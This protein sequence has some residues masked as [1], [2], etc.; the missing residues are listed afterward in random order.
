MNASA[1][2][3]SEAEQGNRADPVFSKAEIYVGAIFFAI[4]MVL[5]FLG[6][7]LTCAVFIQKPHLRTPTN[8]SIAILAFSDILA[9]ILVMPFSLASFI[10]EKWILR[11]T[12]C[13]LNAYAIQALFGVTY[14]SITCTAVI[15]YFRVVRPS[16][17]HYMKPKR[18]L[19]VILTLWLAFLLLLLFPSFVEFPEGRYNRK[20]CFCRLIY[21]KKEAKKLA[22]IQEAVILTFGVLLALMVFTAHYKVFRFVAHHNQMVVPN[23]QQGRSSHIEEAKVSK[24]LVTV[25]VGFAVCWAPTGIN[26]AMDVTKPIHKNK[27]PVF[28]IFLQTILIFTSS[29]INPLIY[30]FT[31][32]RFKQEYMMFLRTLTLIFIEGKE[33]NT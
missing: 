31:N 1:T 14:I 21:N 19:I 23:L 25:V 10:N 3:T 30:T 4:L 5:A 15:R 13:V 7:L 18:T 2:D 17:H 22:R 32:R 27:V 12:T 24:T 28:L 16:F 20:H 26:Q 11:Q 33:L 8:V 6:N 9:A 29:A